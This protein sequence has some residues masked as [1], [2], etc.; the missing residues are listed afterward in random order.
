MATKRIDVSPDFKPSQFKWSEFGE[1]AIGAGAAE[2]DFGTAPVVRDA[3]YEAIEA[4]VHGYLPPSIVADVCT[5]SARWQLESYG[6][7]VDPDDIR[8]VPDAITALSIVVDHFTPP[9]MPVIVPTP[10]YPRFAGVA[11]TLGRPVVPIGL[12]RESGRY[13]YDIDQLREALAKAG[14]GLFVLCNPQNP[15]GFVADSH[16]LLEISGVVSHYDGR[17]LA[18]ELH[19]PLTYSPKSHVP[20]A[21]LS[22][23]S[24]RHA[25][26]VI[27]ASK[28]WNLSG[29]KC[30]EVILTNPLDKESWDRLDRLKLSV[31]A[32]STLGALATVA[33]YTSGRPW[34]ESVIDY[35]QCNSLIIED[36]VKSEVPD[37]GYRAPDATFLA[38][39][40]VRR[41]RGVSRDPA[42][43]FLDGARV[44]MVDGR[45]FGPGG[46][47]FVR[48]NFATS[49]SVLVQALERMKNAI[50][51]LPRG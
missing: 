11:R 38:W 22:A 19:G 5:S 23:E 26:T 18:D 7:V 48:L 40:D 51:L 8:L 45:D 39:L 32:T 16:E 49:S 28:A 24:A 17:V 3:L 42:R 50:G 36:F 27:S 6:W 37:I 21:S 33:A 43:Y 44:A 9:T 47:G 14:G 2:M 29:M 10:A 46:K 20:Y 41:L 13:R 35:L 30:A 15:T 1:G 12:S 25:I 34:L 31:N 4:G